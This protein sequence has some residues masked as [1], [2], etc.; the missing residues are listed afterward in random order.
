MSTDDGDPK[1]VTDITTR[2]SGEDPVTI[3]AE[4]LCNVIADHQ[5]TSPEERLLGIELAFR[6]TTEALRHVFG[7]TE[8]NTIIVEV[9]RRARQY[10]TVWESSQ[11]KTLA[12]HVAEV[13]PLRPK[14]SEEGDNG[15]SEG[16]PPPRSDGGA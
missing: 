10:T 15:K 7:E 6:A 11:G 13:V 5:H 2:K 14:A 8:L 4:D 9:N 16:T 12:R 1:V 3:L